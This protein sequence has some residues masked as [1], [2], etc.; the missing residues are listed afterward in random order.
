MVVTSFLGPVL[1]DVFAR[2]MVAAKD[3]LAIPAGALADD[4]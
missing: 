2:R 3:E 4:S 1:T